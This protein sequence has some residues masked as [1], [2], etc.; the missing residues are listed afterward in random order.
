M[1]VWK[2]GRFGE[3]ETGNGNWRRGDGEGYLRSGK[4]KVLDLVSN[5]PEHEAAINKLLEQKKRL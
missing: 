4:A 5:D 3:W 2:R 1:G